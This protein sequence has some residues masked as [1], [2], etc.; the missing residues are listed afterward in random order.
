MKTIKQKPISFRTVMKNKTLDEY[1]E[2]KDE[3]DNNKN[4]V[5]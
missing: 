1:T 5:K 4:M 2:K 3:S